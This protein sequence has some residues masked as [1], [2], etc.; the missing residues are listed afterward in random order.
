MHTLPS[1]HPTDADFAAIRRQGGFYVDKTGLFRDLLET[2]P[3]AI[4]SPPLTCRHQFLARPRRFGKTLLV[5]TLEAWFQGLPPG[6]RTNPA[7][8][9]AP[10]D[11]LPAGWTS[12]PWLWKGLDT[13]DRH[14]VHGWHPVIRLDLSLID[15]PNP[16]GT[17]TALQ[18]YLWQV[19]AL[20]GERTGRWE[21]SDPLPPRMCPRRRSCGT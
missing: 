11:G 14:G 5:N 7:G 6:H 10:L 12:P 18:A 4:S 19:N 20:W 9:T 21:V 13:Q 17:R 2:Y 1:L 16:A 15:S 3:S 8:D